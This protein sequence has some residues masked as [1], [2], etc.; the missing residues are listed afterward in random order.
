MQGIGLLSNAFNIQV[1]F[2]DAII[3]RCDTILTAIIIHEIRAGHIIMLSCERHGNAGCHD[4]ESVEQI[5]FSINNLG[6]R[7]SRRRCRIIIQTRTIEV[8]FSIFRCVPGTVRQA[9]VLKQECH[10]V[11]IM[12][13]IRTVYRCLA[14]DTRKVHFVKVIPIIVEADPTTLKFAV[15][16]IVG[17]AVNRLQAGI[18]RFSAAIAN[19]LIAGNLEGMFCCGNGGSPLYRRVTF[20]TEGSAG[21]SVLGTSRSFIIQCNRSVNVGCQ[22]FCPISLVHTVMVCIHFGINMEFFIGEY[23]ESRA[24]IAVNK[25]DFTL[26]N[27]HLHILRPEFKVCP[28]SCCCLARNSHI[29]VKVNNTNRNLGKNS[30]SGHIIITCTGNGDISGICFSYDRVFSSETFGKLHMVKLPMVY[31]VQINYCR[32]G[33]DCFNLVRFKIHPID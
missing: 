33:L 24:C 32:N 29:I 18:G 7:R 8:H 1:V 6:H 9:A 5:G 23:I 26:I 21:I 10:A 3:Q 27:I 30:F 31:I 16:G 11:C 22:V 28:Y 17:L 14:I 4:A 12:V 20:R 2:V 25:G 13:H 15:N 19:E